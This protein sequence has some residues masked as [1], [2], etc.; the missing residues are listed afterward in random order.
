MVTQLIETGEFLFREVDEMLGIEEVSNMLDWTIREQIR[1]IKEAIIAYRQDPR[2]EIKTDRVAELLLNF[3][4][5]ANSY[6]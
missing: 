6:V 4:D 5:T 3:D 2:C 1:D